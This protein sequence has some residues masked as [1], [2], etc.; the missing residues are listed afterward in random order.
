[1]TEGAL[2]SL[3]LIVVIAL[4]LDSKG[5]IVNTTS[6]NARPNS[7]RVSKVDAKIQMVHTFAVATMD[8]AAEIANERIPAY[9]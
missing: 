5:I 6:M 7:T 9:W 8:S 3:M 2:I 1:M 4:E